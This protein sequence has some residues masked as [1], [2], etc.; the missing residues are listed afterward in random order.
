[1]GGSSNRGFFGASPQRV[2]PTIMWPVLLCACFIFGLLVSA[3]WYTSNERRKREALVVRRYFEPVAV[4][5][6]TVAILSG[7][8]LWMG[9]WDFIDEYLVP[10]EW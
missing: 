8:L 3:L 1:M 10:K 7:V 2:L 9:F 5:E 6:A 4:C